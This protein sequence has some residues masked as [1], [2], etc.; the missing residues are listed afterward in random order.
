[1]VMQ[2]DT[3]LGNYKKGKCVCAHDGSDAIILAWDDDL[4]EYEEYAIAPESL[5][6]S[7]GLLAE[8]SYRGKSE[9]DRTVFE[10]DRMIWH[11]P[12]D[13]SY[14]S[15]YPVVV[16]WKKGEFVLKGEYFGDIMRLADEDLNEWEII[17]TVHDAEGAGSDESIDTF[18]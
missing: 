7:T 2:E 17:G 18:A 1:M 10:G 3:L 12:H 16:V 15:E 13:D 8:K 5:G 4:H 6:Q 11:D 14:I 9:D